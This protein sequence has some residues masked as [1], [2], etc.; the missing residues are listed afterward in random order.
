MRLQE[1]GDTTA[2]P[3]LFFERDDLAVQ[4]GNMR[5][6]EIEEWPAQIA[7][8]ALR[9]VD[10]QANMAMEATLGKPP[11]TLPLD[12]IQIIHVG[13][14]LRIEWAEILE[15]SPGVRIA[16]NP[17][18]IG[19]WTKTAEQTADLKHVWGAGYDGYLES[20]WVCR[21]VMDT[22]KREYVHG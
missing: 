2:I 9:L 10:H 18:F 14:V 22:R 19:Q 20:A 17:P 4:L 15:P 11:E 12:T 7:R 21:R 1:L 13:N 3:A 8:M 16:G 5:G 6:I